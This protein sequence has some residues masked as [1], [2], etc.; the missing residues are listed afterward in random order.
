MTFLELY[1]VELDGELGSADRTS[2]FTEVRRKAAINKAQTW[3]VTQTECLQRTASITLTDAVGEYDLED[4][5]S[6][7]D[8]LW[9]AKQGPEIAADPGGGGEIVYY[10]GR[11]FARTTVQELNLESSG[12]RGLDPGTPERWYERLDGGQH[13]FGLVPAPSIP[14]AATWTLNVP[15]VVKAAAMSADGDLPFTVSSN[16]KVSLIPWHDA[17][18][19]Y[20]ASEL[21]KLRKGTER[22]VFL[23]QQAEARVLDY[24]DKRRVPGGKRVRLARSYHR[25]TMTA[26]ISDWGPYNDPWK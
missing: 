1:G 2:L 25:E 12:W 23:R 7:A 6:D 5:I 13:I 10:A 9:I 11:E 22:S 4:E 8:F 14:V 17:L 21:E 18:V 20:A 26:K 15:Y 16:A 3:F 19:Y 24:L